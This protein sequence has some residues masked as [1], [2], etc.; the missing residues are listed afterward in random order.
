MQTLGSLT[1]TMQLSCKETQHLCKETKKHA[2]SRLTSC[3]FKLD[4]LSPNSQFG[5]PCN[6]NSCK[7]E[8]YNGQDR[9][10]VD[11]GVVGE[12][13]WA[14]GEQK[15]SLDEHDW[16]LGR[17]LESISVSGVRFVGFRWVLPVLLLP[18]FYSFFVGKIVESWV[19]SGWSLFL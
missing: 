7:E 14:L 19:S 5:K 11:G 3:K 16:S 9:E 4:N 17:T 8:R 1:L 2:H 18:C 13:K 6:A 15:W 10:K 12:Q